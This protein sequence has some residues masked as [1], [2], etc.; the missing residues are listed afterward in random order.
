MPNV[1][2]HVSPPNQR[3]AAPVA[4]PV[5]H[6]ATFVAMPSTNRFTH[7]PA[8][9]EDWMPAGEVRFALRP[10]AEDEMLVAALRGRLTELVYERCRRCRSLIAVDSRRDDPQLLAEIYRQLPDAYWERLNPQLYFGATLERYLG[11]RRAGGD[12]WDIGCGAGN[13]LAAFGSQWIKT[14]IEPGLAGAEI[15]RRRGLKV[16]VGTA[17]TLRLEQVADAALLIDVIEHL[18]DPQ[19]ELAA[20]REM[21]RPGGVLAVLTGA[22]DAWTARFA[23]P[24]WYYLHCLGHVTILSGAGLRELLGKLGFADVATHRVEHP[25][26]VGGIRWLKR[27]GGNVLRRVLGK[28]PAAMHHFRDHQLVLAAKPIDIAH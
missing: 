10:D 16:L 22:A 6:P 14:G 8:C 4:A 12:L 11:E 17:A 19:L 28:E 23:G 27:I 1:E 2:S 13:L 20:I 25:G 21:L 5:W 18:L 24:R 3:I 9:L 7:C 26:A 15:A